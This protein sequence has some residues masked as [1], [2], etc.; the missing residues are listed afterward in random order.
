[1]YD[2][3][4]GNVSNGENEGSDCVGVSLDIKRL[5][6]FPGLNSDQNSPEFGLPVGE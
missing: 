1:M 5:L 6:V 3:T 4:L 2:G